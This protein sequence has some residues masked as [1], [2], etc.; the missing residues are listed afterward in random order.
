MVLKMAS[1]CGKIT[2][3]I[4]YIWCTYS[5]QAQA[6]IFVFLRAYGKKTVEM[7]LCYGCY[8]CSTNKR[9]TYGLFV[10][11]FGWFCFLVIFDLP[12]SISLLVALTW[13]SFKIECAMCNVHVR[14]DQKESIFRLKNGKIHSRPKT[15]FL[16]LNYP[17]NAHPTPPKMSMLN[18]NFY[19]WQRIYFACM[20]ICII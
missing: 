20:L 16:I 8:G 4:T 19:E 2:I 18:L 6:R 12:F 13:F 15:G 11:H 7:K 10:W 5:A 14:V 17:N 9:L 3:I 1:N